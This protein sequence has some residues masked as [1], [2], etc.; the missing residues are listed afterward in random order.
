MRHSLKKKSSLE[1]KEEDAAEKSLG[2]VRKEDDIQHR[3]EATLV[4]N[5]V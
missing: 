1:D 2:V 3:S 4:E 5:Q